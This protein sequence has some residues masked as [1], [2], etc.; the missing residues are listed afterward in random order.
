MPLPAIA[1]GF[2]TPPGG[3]DAAP[4]AGAAGRRVRR[5]GGRGVLAI[6]QARGQRPPE[7]SMIAPV[8]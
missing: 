3:A 7:T 1:V 5:W 4:T 2:F 8:V 6:G